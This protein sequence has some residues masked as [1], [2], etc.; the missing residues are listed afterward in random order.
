MDNFGLP[1][2]RGIPT[3][4][5]DNVAMRPSPEFAS[6]AAIVP[7]LQPRSK[8]LRR[9]AAEVTGASMAT[10]VVRPRR[11]DYTHGDKLQFAILSLPRREI[12]SLP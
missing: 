12:F 9:G 6:S 2:P 5:I 8:K 7:R 1:W 10:L 11:S 3:T 4:C